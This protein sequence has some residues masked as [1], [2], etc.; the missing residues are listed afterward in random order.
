MLYQTPLR[1]LPG[2]ALPCYVFDSHQDLARHVAQMI[3]GVIRERDGVR[4]EGRARPADRLHAGGRLPRAD[5][6]AP[7][8]RA[9]L[10]ARRHLQPRRILRPA[11]RPA[12][13]LSPL[14]ARDFFKHVNIPPE[15]IHIPDGTDAAGR[16][17]TTTAAATKPRSSGPAASTCNCWASAATGTSASTSRSALRNSRTRAGHA[18]PVTRRD[19]ASDFFSEENVP[20]QAITMG[21]GTILDARKIVLIALGEHKAGI[22]RETVEGPHDRPRAGQLSARHPDAT[23][24]LD[25]GRRRQADRRRHALGAG[26]RRLDRRADQAGRALALASRRARRCSSSTTTISASTTCTSCCGITARRR[27]WPIACSAG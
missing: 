10:L 7:R 27:A 14:D 16:A 1:P 26:Q 19:A 24:L 12:A 2:T 3:A 8:G 11:A 5:P 25:D 17:S 23:F 22:V 9:R 20:T 15:N 4:P 18:R 13:Q 6:P 21:V